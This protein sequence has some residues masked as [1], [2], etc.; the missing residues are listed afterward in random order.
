MNAIIIVD[1]VTKIVDFRMQMGPPLW[2]AFEGTKVAQ[3][4]TLWLGVVEGGTHFTYI[5]QVSLAIFY[6]STG[7]I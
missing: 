7:L 6:A 1:T 4:L 2:P 5:A 3:S